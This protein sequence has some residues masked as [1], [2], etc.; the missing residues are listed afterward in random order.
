MRGSRWPNAGNG[1]PDGNIP[2]V[3]PPE[4]LRERAQSFLDSVLTQHPGRRVVAVS[5]RRGFI[6][7]VLALVSQGRIGTGKTLLGNA[8]VSTVTAEFQAGPKG[9]SAAASKLNRWDSRNRRDSGE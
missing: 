7:A 4:S 1:F 5:P 2:G 9:L 8:S 3:E 6:N